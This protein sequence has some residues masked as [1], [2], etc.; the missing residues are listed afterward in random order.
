METIS[1]TDSQVQSRIKGAKIERYEPECA[2]STAPA[3][4]L[5]KLG[6]K[7]LGRQHPAFPK[8][9]RF[10]GLLPGTKLSCENH[11]HPLFSF[12]TDDGVKFI[13]HGHS[14]EAVGEIPA[15]FVYYSPVWPPTNHPKEMSAHPVCAFCAADLDEGWAEAAAE[16]AMS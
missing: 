3:H 10:Y 11:R 6:L 4:P 1:L 14:E 9:Y 7:E 2:F 13:E 15:E 12:V 8:R 5:T 16:A